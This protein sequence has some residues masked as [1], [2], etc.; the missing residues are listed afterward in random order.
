MARQ[1]TGTKRTTKTTKT[2]RTPKRTTKTLETL[3][4]SSKVKT[5]I[6]NFGCNTSS[7]AITGLNE[8]LHWHITQAAGRAK[9]NGRKT[10]RAHDFITT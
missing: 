4:V 8:I 7:D 2:T 9:A 3:A 5:T 10:V 1:K 6:R